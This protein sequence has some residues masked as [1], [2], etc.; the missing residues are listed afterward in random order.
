MS[1]LRKG[2]VELINT[3]GG[4]EAAS[5]A[6]WPNR[7]S[8]HGARLLRN[9]MNPSKRDKPDLEDMEQ[10][11]WIGRLRGIHVAINSL[12][13]SLNYSAPQVIDP[14]AKLTLLHQSMQ[15]HQRALQEITDAM[16]RA[17]QDI[18]A[19][20]AADSKGGAK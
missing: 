20:A 14:K 3:L 5:L 10:L 19:I 13:E 8:E 18:D 2:L 17:Q 1:S 16:L 4:Y 9:W 6:L 7:K 15:Q 12:C 11:L